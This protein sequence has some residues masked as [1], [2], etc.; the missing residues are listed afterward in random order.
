MPCSAA[1]APVAA[2]EVQGGVGLRRGQPPLQLR[3]IRLLPLHPYLLQNR[4]AVALRHKLLHH[5][6]QLDVPGVHRLQAPQAAGWSSFTG[7]VGSQGA[8]MPDNICCAFRQEAALQGQLQLLLPG[9]HAPWQ[10]PALHPHA[11]VLQPLLAKPRDHSA[12][13]ES[14]IRGPAGWATYQPR[15]GASLLCCRRSRRHPNAGDQSS[16]LPW[17]S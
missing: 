15:P 2:G 11:L 16:H 3:H 7:R 14:M 4:R 6:Q 12:S 5:W 10:P 1:A 9:R 13:S 17:Q 8:S